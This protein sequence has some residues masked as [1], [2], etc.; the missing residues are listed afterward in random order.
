[1]KR[2]LVGILALLA[3]GCAQ[4]PNKATLGGLTGSALGAGIGAII[5][6][7]SGNAG[8]GVA[9]GAAAGALGGALIGNSLDARDNENQALNDRLSQQEKSLEE[10]KR[11]IEELRAK[12]TDVRESRRGVVINLP[13]VLFDFDDDQLTNDA[14]RTVSEI[15]EILKTVEDR[16]ISV[17]GHTDSI[18]TVVY[19]K[20]LSERRA[21]AVASS[22][23]ANGLP[24]MRIRQR[25]YG[26]GSPITTN[27]SP[28]GRARNR[29]VEVIVENR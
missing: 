8:Q 25:G 9:I 6:N 14:D 21:G 4:Q 26:E 24:Q 27:N 20:N 13:D 29:R 2:I 17:E 3:A 5:G 18:G 1:M 15:A 28:E 7:Q 19:N 16:Q 23:A 12:G 22:L 11:L 10:N